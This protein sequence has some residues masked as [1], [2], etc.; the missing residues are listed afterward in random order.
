MEPQAADRSV[1]SG[2]TLIEAVVTLAV[3]AI[4]SVGLV[5]VAASAMTAL[6]EA[7]TREDLTDMQR[8]V[9]ETRSLSQEEHGL[10]SATSATWVTCL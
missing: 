10:P 9:A 6:L 2:F 4:I 7:T 1:N 5:S 3:I 8:A